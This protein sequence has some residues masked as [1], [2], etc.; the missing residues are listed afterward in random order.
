MTKKGRP[1]EF[2]PEKYGVADEFLGHDWIGK[3]YSSDLR[4]V[5][6]KLRHYADYL[7]L[8]ADFL[9]QQMGLAFE[10]ARRVSDMLDS[11]DATGGKIAVKF[12]KDTCQ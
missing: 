1:T 12:P 5:A 6:N 11:I 4:D 8:K 10:A 7:D 9:E 3:F 2:D